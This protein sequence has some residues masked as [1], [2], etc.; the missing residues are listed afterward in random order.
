MLQ[1]QSGAPLLGRGGIAAFAF[2]ATGILHRMAFVKDND[3][4]EVV[5]QPIDDLLH[6]GNPVLAR[7]GA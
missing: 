3:P 1:A 4:I 2:A 7:I 5:A 6:P